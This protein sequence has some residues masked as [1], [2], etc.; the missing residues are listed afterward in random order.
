MMTFYAAIGTYRI[1]T[2]NG[3]KVPYIQKLGKLYPISIPEFVIWSTLLWEVMTYDELKKHYD[4]QIRELK[5]NRPSF[6]ELLSM[7]AKRKLIVKGMGYTGVDAL[8]NM[9]SDA[10]VIP[11]RISGGRRLWSVLKLWHNGKISAHQACKILK[12]R[13]STKMEDRVM[14]LVEQTPLSTAEIIRCV[15]RGIE[16]VSTADKVIAGVYPDSAQ[17]TIANEEFMS[18]YSNDVLEA[19]SNLYL[20]HEVVLEVV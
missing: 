2:E 4:E 19:I 17:A 16:D 12:T 6:D 11:F 7:L 18:E 5:G 3:H 13:V 10:F 14:R 9:L 1:R 20:N 15:E 8:Y